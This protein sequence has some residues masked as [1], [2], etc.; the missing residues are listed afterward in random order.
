MIIKTFQ[1][2][3]REGRVKENLYSCEAETRQYIELLSESLKQT[4]I[5]LLIKVIRKEI[6]KQRKR[7]GQMKGKKKGFW[8]Y[9]SPRH[10]DIV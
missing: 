9:R 3:S 7:K 1:I 4:P 2:K 5:E 10:V 8:M 6:V